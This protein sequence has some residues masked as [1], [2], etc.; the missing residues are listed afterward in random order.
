MRRGQARDLLRVDK[1]GFA[2]QCITTS[3]LGIIH[4][5][6]IIMAVVVCVLLSSK[7]YCTLCFMFLFCFSF[8]VFLGGRAQLFGSDWTTA[9]YCDIIECLVITKF[10]CELCVCGCASRR[11]VWLASRDWGRRVVRGMAWR[12]ALLATLCVLLRC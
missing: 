9:T 10:G 7:Y 11:I 4:T 1:F 2:T 5:R 12:R 6:R 8:C 3:I